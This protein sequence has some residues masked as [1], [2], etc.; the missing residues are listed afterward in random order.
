MLD[1]LG[2]ARFDI[3]SNG[4]KSVIFD[5]SNGVPTATLDIVFE[6]K[7][8]INTEAAGNVT[9]IDFSSTNLRLVGGASL[10][11]FDIS[12]S[13]NSAT[14][15]DVKLKNIN[16]YNAALRFNTNANVTGE[17]LSNTSIVVE[18]GD[19]DWQMASTNL[20]ALTVAAGAVFTYNGTSNLTVYNADIA[21]TLTFNGANSLNLSSGTISG[22]LNYNSS[23]NMNWAFGDFSGTINYGQTAGTLTWATGNNLSGVL[24][25]DNA[26][27][28]TWKGGDV[29]SSAKIN[30]INNTGRII[31]EDGVM[32]GTLITSG[33][34]VVSGYMDASGD[35]MLR[36]QTILM[37]SSNSVL[38]LN[39][40]NAIS[41]LV[42]TT[43]EQYD[44]A[45][46][47][48][49]F[50]VEGTGES[51]KYYKKEYVQ[52]SIAADNAQLVIGK[53]NRIGTLYYS[54]YN[55]DISS[56]IV[57]SGEAVLA[58]EKFGALANSVTLDIENYANYRIFLIDASTYN[59]ITEINANTESGSSFNKADLSLIA[60][61]WNGE[62]GYWLNAVPE[63]AEWAT[64]LGALALAVAIR[65]RMR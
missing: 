58:I 7:I 45:S 11:Y 30:N 52:I 35:I 8:D 56:S 57:F 19:V 28:M 3:G 1:S 49:N 47:K 39:K 2:R 46:D 44:S 27:D 26:R 17:T 62:A 40:E 60:G 65:R 25:Y 20:D 53:N 10:T 31:W 5:A 23:A 36:N 61:V 37:D 43:K 38:S 15:A 32:G 24:N 14:V 51:A 59:L 41:K 12:N 9:A 64:I 50:V 16:G 6:T 34:L 13:K 55:D 63:P 42:E 33:R 22:V 18:K 29:L 54:K 4:A 48:S 21:G